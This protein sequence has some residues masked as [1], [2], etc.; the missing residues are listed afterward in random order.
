MKRCPG[1][2]AMSA[3]GMSQREIATALGVSQP[4]VS[5]QLKAAHDL[6]RVHPEALVKAAAPVPRRR[7]EES[8]Y[9]RLAVLA[10]I[11][12]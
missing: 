10:S 2:R 12:R 6:T 3:T 4:A 5:Q 8:G 9:G 7:A 1:A 11:H